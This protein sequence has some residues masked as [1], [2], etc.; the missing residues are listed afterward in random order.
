MKR[1]RE[2]KRRLRPILWLLS[3]L[4]RFFISKSRP[5][6]VKREREKEKQDEAREF[7][8]K[9][10]GMAVSSRTERKGSWKNGRKEN[11]RAVRTTIRYRLVN[12]RRNN[13]KYKCK[14]RYT[15]LLLYLLYC[16]PREFFA[17]CTHVIAGPSSGCKVGEWM[18]VAVGAGRCVSGRKLGKKSAWTKNCVCRFT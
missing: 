6:W 4:V 12:Q 9:V 11:T 8:R 2:N 3:R 7:F 1:E 5:K 16:N 13:V 18:A 17:A 14:S 10:L 15:L